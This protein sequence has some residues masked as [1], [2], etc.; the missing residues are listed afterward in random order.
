MRVVLRTS[1]FLWENVTY[2][3]WCLVSWL[4][5]VSKHYIMCVELYNL[6]V[7]CC[8]W[9]SIVWYANIVLLNVRGVR[10]VVSFATLMVSFATLMNS[11]NDTKAAIFPIQAKFPNDLPL[12]KLIKPTTS[13]ALCL[14]SGFKMSPR[15]TSLW[16]YVFWSPGSWN[17][18]CI[19]FR[20]EKSSRV[21]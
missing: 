16:R 8:Q 20:F 5:H 1:L 13:D 17:V 14:G 9:I 19:S 18:Q 3:N 7:F 2:Y 21:K 6:K 12:L 4:K 11:F 15:T 10:R